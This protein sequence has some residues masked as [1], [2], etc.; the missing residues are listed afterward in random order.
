MPR[1]LTVSQTTSDT[2]GDVEDEALVDRS[3]I[4]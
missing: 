1:S 3:L 2:L 4:L